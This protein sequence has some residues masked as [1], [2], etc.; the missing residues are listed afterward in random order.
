MDMVQLNHPQNVSGVFVGIIEA[1]QAEIA[2]PGQELKVFQ[3]LRIGG[4]NGAGATVGML[5]VTKSRI[6]TPPLNATEEGALF[7]LKRHDGWL[8]GFLG[9]AGKNRPGPKEEQRENNDA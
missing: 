2:I 9:G 6:A 8:A 3:H 7:L 4:I 1:N 5:S